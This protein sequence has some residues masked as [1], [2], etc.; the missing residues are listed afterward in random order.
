VKQFLLS[1]DSDGLLVFNFRSMRSLWYV[2]K[3]KNSSMATENVVSLLTGKMKRLPLV[4][5]SSLPRVACFGSRFTIPMFQVVVDRYCTTDDV[6]EAVQIRSIGK[7]RKAMKSENEET[8]ILEEPMETSQEKVKKKDWK[9]EQLLSICEKEGLLWLI[10]GA[11]GTNGSMIRS[12]K[13]HCFLSTQAS[14]FLFSSM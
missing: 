8:V 1:L 3:I 9:H 14:S 4:L 11:V 10:V 6:T 2:E 12:K 7:S 5:Q 13:P